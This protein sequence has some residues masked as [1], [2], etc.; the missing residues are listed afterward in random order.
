MPTLRH[1]TLERLEAC[2]FPVEY[3]PSARAQAGRIAQRLVRAHSYLRDVLDFDPNVCLRVLAPSDWATCAG[4]PLYGMPHVS[5][6]TT[7]VMGTD[8]APFWQEIVD[9]IDAFSSPAQRVAAEAVYGTAGGRI[10]MSGFADLIAV[11]EL[12]HLF[13]QQAPF[14]FPR[15][16]LM[17]LFA[18]YCVHA[19]VAAVEPDCMSLWTN[20]PSRIMAVPVDRVRFRTLEQ[21]ERM[22]VGASAANYVWY[23][24][25]LLMALTKIHDATGVAGLQRLYRECRSLGGRPLDDRSLVEFLRVQVDPSAALVIEEWPGRTHPTRG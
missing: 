11:H 13:H 3:S 2:P 25:R 9:L 12:G 8:P 5:G 7:I 17:E 20:L 16:W 21:F 19:Y 4:F 18:N 6:N 24:F 14:G 23:E 22:D 15:S 10:D 1:S